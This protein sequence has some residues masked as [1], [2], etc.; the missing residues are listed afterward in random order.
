MKTAIKGFWPLTNLL[1]RKDRWKILIWL[2]CLVGVSVA[3]ALAYPEV[4]KTDEDI[5][6]FALTME[7][8][9]MK[10][11]IG[12]GYELEAYTSTAQIFAHELL[13]F[14]TIAVA[15]MNILIVSRAT[16]ADEEEGKTELVLS[17]PVGRLS[18]LLAAIIEAIAINLILALATGI[19]LYF[20]DLDGFT[21]EGSFL[22]GAI[23]GSIGL[24]FAG[25]TALFAQLMETTRGATGWAFVIMIGGYILRAF[26]DVEKETLSLLTPYGWATR[27]YVFVDN[28][29]WPVWVSLAFGIILL[30]VSFYLN[31]L[32]DVGAGFI[33]ARKGRAH[34]SSFIK[35]PSGFVLR[36]QRLN[37]IG[38]ALGLFFLSAAF[39]SI[40]GELES[41]FSDLDLM[42]ILF[43]DDINFSL[44]FT[45]LLMAIMAIFGV[46]PA[47]MALLSLKGEETNTRTEH[48]YARSVS[49]SKVMVSYFAVGLLIT[50]IMQ[51]M[52]A[53]GFWFAASSVMEEA[54]TAGE[55]FR[56]AFLYL[57]AM[58]VLVALVVLLVGAYPR[59]SVIIWLYFGYC[60]FVTYFKEILDVPDWLAKISVFELIPQYPLEAMDW[61]PLLALIA[62]TLV[63][64]IFGFVGYNR[65]D[66]TG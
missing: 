38:W 20:L 53:S 10:A 9:G 30:I 25:I 27:A 33:R 47:I 7:N 15:V 14:T 39:G 49:R 6:G 41:Y 57:P 21:A 11:M 19:S 60:F 36:Q 22:Y 18:Y 43:Q 1:F 63:L 13:L 3:S 8:P 24:F 52:T 44:Q 23:L 12:P 4:Y 64:T 37:I 34:A 51:G 32:R 17:L 45:V 50:V 16:R 65:R 58:W 28:D 42:K 61:S 40:M 62:V 46:V 48:L 56:S 35:T 54:L 55:V 26:G 66:I 29:W 2:L 5:M 59:G 31:S